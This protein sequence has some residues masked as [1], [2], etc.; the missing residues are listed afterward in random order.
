MTRSNEEPCSN[1]SPVCLVKLNFNILRENAGIAVATR[2]YLAI[3][4]N[5]VNDSCGTCLGLAA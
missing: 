4:S 5:G 2:V 3:G 1:H